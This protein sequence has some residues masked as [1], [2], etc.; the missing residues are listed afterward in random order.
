MKTGSLA[1]SND[2]LWNPNIEVK[3]G[4][5]FTIE[6]GVVHELENN[7]SNSLILIVTC[8]PSHLEWNRVAAV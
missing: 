5:F 8:S 7:S 6:P 2:I 1:P 3:S 4:D